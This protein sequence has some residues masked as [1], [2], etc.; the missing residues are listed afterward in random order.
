M[1]KA[2]YN[3]LRLGMELVTSK[4]SKALSQLSIG[5]PEAYLIDSLNSIFLNR[6]PERN[7]SKFNTYA[8]YIEHT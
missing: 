6:R 2:W 8:I 4:Q 1:K 7:N 3:L 5:S